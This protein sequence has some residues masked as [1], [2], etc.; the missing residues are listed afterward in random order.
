M[1]PPDSI[2][3]GAVGEQDLL[4]MAILMICSNCIW[5]V[6]LPLFCQMVC[7]QSSHHTWEKITRKVFLDTLHRWKNCYTKE[8]AGSHEDDR[9]KGQEIESR[10]AYWGSS[11][12]VLPSHVPGITV[13]FL[14]LWSVLYGI[15]HVNKSKCPP[16][17]TV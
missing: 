3:K 2:C 13:I 1:S 12:P 16:C 14:L 9:Q 8:D 15:I 5:L 6:I 7:R 4:V 10:L 11:L 17:Y